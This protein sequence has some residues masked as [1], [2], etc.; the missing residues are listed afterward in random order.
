MT[1]AA[2]CATC[3]DHPLIPF[4]QGADVV[5]T[6]GEA[7]WHIGRGHDVRPYMEESMKTDT[8]T[9]EDALLGGP[10]LYGYAYQADVYCVDCGVDIARAVFAER[11]EVDGM[12]FGDSE[13][14]P[15]PIFSGENLDCAEYCGDCGEYL[16][17]DDTV[18]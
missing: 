9:L 6:A 12:T 1:A 3:T 14:V 8:Y 5:G 16:Y 13:E 2:Y 18:E 4:V 10:G 17:G 11:P 7:V 15:Q